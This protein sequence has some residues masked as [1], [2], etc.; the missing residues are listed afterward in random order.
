M[1]KCDV[2][3]HP[4]C[5]PGNRLRRISEDVIM[6]EKILPA[7]MLIVL[8]ATFTGCGLFGPT[9]TKKFTLYE[10]VGSSAGKAVGS[11]SQKNA[12]EECQ[13]LGW[14]Q[15]EDF[16]C[17]TEERGCGSFFGCFD[18]DVMYTVTCSR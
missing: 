5:S 3:Q 1:D 18:Q 14:D 11:C 4:V 15:A 10:F 8:I 16:E 7:L 6:K 17:G 2:F 12:D 9:E 13:L